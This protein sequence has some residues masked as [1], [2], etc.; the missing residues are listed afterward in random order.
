M[1]T[2]KHQRRH[3][4]ELMPDGSVEYRAGEAATVDLLPGGRV[5]LEWARLTLTLSDAQARQLTGRILDAQMDGRDYFQKS[6][7]A[8]DAAIRRH[9]LGPDA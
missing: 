5:V 3:G 2:T 9:L 8:T 7:D 6:G 1:K 4:I